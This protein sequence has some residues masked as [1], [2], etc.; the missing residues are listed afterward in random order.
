MINSVLLC[1]INLFYKNHFDL[2]V[3]QRIIHL[4]TLE[5]FPWTSKVIFISISVGVI[6]FVFT[7]ACVFANWDKNKKTNSSTQEIV[8][9]RNDLYDSKDSLPIMDGLSN[10]PDWL[11]DRKE[12]VFS[13]NSI[14]KGKPIGKG[15]FGNVFKGTFCHGNAV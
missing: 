4:V 5:N 15:Q 14:I 9:K 8:W 3:F 10:L 11:N 2:L 13:E 7:V 1:F 12:M 6:I